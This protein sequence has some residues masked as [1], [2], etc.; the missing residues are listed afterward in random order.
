MSALDFSERL[1]LSTMEILFDGRTLEEDETLSQIAGELHVLFVPI[2]SVECSSRKSSG[3]ACPEEGLLVVKIPDGVMHIEAKAFQCCRLLVK[4]TIP[5]TVTH[6]FEFAFRGCGSLTSLNIPD[7]LT[8]IGTS[9]FSGCK[10]ST[11]TLPR[12]HLS[13]VER[14]AF[15][16]CDSLVSLELP[17]TL[18]VIEE[19]VGHG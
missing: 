1:L 4:V 13:Y 18:T 16:F 8:W 7:S 12:S 6:I 14:G 3:L 15:Q 11:L 10:F 19:Q 5:E 17:K 2:P 9:A